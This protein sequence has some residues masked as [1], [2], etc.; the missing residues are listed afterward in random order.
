MAS[1]RT[2]TLASITSDDGVEIGPIFPGRVLDELDSNPTHLKL[3]LR[4]T[5]T[6]G[7]IARADVEE[8]ATADTIDRP[9]L[10]V[11]RFIE[12]CQDAASRIGETFPDDEVTQSSG[13][14]LQL[15]WAESEWTNKGNDLPVPIGDQP[16]TPFGPFQFHPDVWRTTI[17]DDRYE[18]ILADFTEGSRRFPLDQCYVAACRVDFLQQQLFAATGTVPSVILVR[19]AWLIGQEE[20]ARFAQLAPTDPVD[21][22]V[23]GTQAVSA[24]TLANFVELFVDAGQ[25]RTRAAVEDLVD[26]ALTAAQQAAA[27]RADAFLKSLSP[28]PVGMSD[29]GGPKVMIDDVGLDILTRI[30]ASEAGIFAAFG[31][32]ELKGALTAV[33]DTVINRVAHSAPKFGEGIAGVVDKPGQFQPVTETAGKTWAEL[34]DPAANIKTIIKN[35]IVGRTKDGRESKIKGFTFFLNPNFSAQ[36]EMDRWGTAVKEDPNSVSY[37]TDP[38]IHYHGIPPGE[39]KPP[40]H[41]I[42]FNGNESFFNSEGQLLEPPAAIDASVTALLASA[43][44]EW[45]HWGEATWNTITSA[46]TRTHRDDDEAFAKYILET[47]VPMGGVSTT[48]EAIADDDFPWSAVSLSFILK[49]GGV[50]KNLFAFSASHSVYVREA[51]R[52]RQTEDASKFYWAYRRDE[53]EVGAIP[54]PG[55]LICRARP[56][57]DS[58]ILTEAKALARFDATGAYKSHADLVVAKRPGEIDVIGGNVRDTVTKRTVAINS[59]GKLLNDK[60]FWFAILKKRL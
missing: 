57:S 44:R 34:P 6:I 32:S 50:T 26:A 5:T 49:Q 58:E 12:A 39:T 38:T 4:G 55:D 56:N 3:Q 33:V 17:D 27:N 9:P 37:G 45:K 41:S 2:T 36:S 11:A 28:I 59:D 53:E 22:A 19:I 51:V 8:I 15:A 35:H 23:D 43:G 40:A 29:G 20:G 24:A 13:Q 60:F 1:W 16:E 42:V 14:L 31:E 48:V 30:A 47:Y 18:A 21:T 46:K 25:T 54:E 7:W 52:A 10:H